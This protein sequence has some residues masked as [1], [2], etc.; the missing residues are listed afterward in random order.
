MTILNFLWDYVFIFLF[1]L[2]ILVFVHELGH[3]LV[4]RY[5]N[6]RVEVFSIGFG[7][8]LYGWTDKVGTRWK[9]SAIPLG[10]YVKMFGEKDAVGWDEDERPMTDAERAVSFHHKRLGQRAAIV[11][12]GPLANFLFAIVVLGALFAAVGTPAPLA[13]VGSVAEDSAAARAGLQAGD[14]IHSIDGQ[15]V[16]WFQE[17]SDIVR[18]SPEKTLVLDV[19]RNGSRQLFSAVPHRFEVAGPDGVPQTIGRLGVTPDQAQIGYERRDALTAAWLGVERTFGLCWQ[20]LA[21]LGQII[22]GSQSADQ[23]G[24]P[25]RIAQ[26]SG[27]IAQGSAVNLILF[28]AALSINLGLIN[29]F[30]VPMLDGG[31]LVFYAVEALRGRPVSERVRE[32]SFRFGL[33]LVM[34]LMV[35]ATWNDLTHL[36]FFQFLKQLVT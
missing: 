23:L 32:Y 11:A 28:I 4:A 5:N 1:V 13:G 16:V 27:D 3:Y 14:R 15:P 21:Y 35:F 29:L 12:A 24:G 20:I 10:G 36:K 2:T 17:L 22:N 31:H 25:L 8:E 34:L 18:M 7:A 19:E 33:A 26:M 9:I 30:P 6:V